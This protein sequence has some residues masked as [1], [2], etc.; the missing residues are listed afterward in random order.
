M[1]R[2]CGATDGT[3]DG[4]ADGRG[5]CASLSVPLDM[6]KVDTQIWDFVKKQIF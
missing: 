2:F 1:Q 4:T 6:G 3:A 5:G